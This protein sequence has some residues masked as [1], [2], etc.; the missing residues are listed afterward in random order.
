ML[1]DRT[2]HERKCKILG[3]IFFLVRSN[4]QVQ[5]LLDQ[6]KDVAADTD[7]EQMQKLFVDTFEQ[8]N[9]ALAESDVPPHQGCTAVT[10]L[11]RGTGEQR[12]LYAANAGDARAVLCR[13]GKATR[14]TFDHKASDADEAARVEAAGGFMKNGRVNGMIEITRSIG[15]QLMK[16][17]CLLLCCNFFDVLNASM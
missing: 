11:I 14:L 1:I 16:N 2:F 3:S 9:S 13:D 8:T 10:C 17:V 6:L 12:K 7:D 15:D 5:I 4:D